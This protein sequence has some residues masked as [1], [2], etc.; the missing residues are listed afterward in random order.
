M[1]QLVEELNKCDTFKGKVIMVPLAS[2]KGL[3]VHEKLKNI[4]GI[5]IKRGVTTGFDPAFIVESNKLDLLEKDIVK[6]LLKGKEIKRYL[7]NKDDKYLRIKIRN[8]IRN[9]EKE[10]L[11][12]KKFFKTIK[13]LKYSDAVVTPKPQNPI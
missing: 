4:E 13:N 9:L 8:L 12:K 6:P 2:R 5:G 1:T 7:I 11:D 10:G 3:C